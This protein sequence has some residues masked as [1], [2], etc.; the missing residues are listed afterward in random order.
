METYYILQRLIY[1]FNEDSLRNDIMMR[2]SRVSPSS[3][4][5]RWKGTIRLNRKS[6][7]TQF[8]TWRLSTSNH[9]KMILFTAS[10]VYRRNR[11]H[12]VAFV[13]EPSKRQLVCFDPGYDLYLYGRHKIIPMVAN[14]LHDAGWIDAPI[15]L[16]GPCTQKK[17]HG[18]G[19]Q[20]N[21]EN[22]HKVKL[23]ADAFCQM[24]TLFF[25]VMYVRCNGTLSFFDEWCRINPRY[26][27]FFLL[28]NF[29]LPMINSN[30]SKRSLSVLNVSEEDK[31]KIETYVTTTFWTRV[32]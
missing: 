15:V 30:L 31:S 1:A 7:F 19:I 21:G 20:Y 16:H 32:K 5:A 2:T 10:Y 25:L 26:R 22:P 3:N 4:K 14:A 29:T 9:D 24:W 28:Q 11:V 6:T 17:Q 8:R 27:E 23:P 18:F 12:Y 13:L